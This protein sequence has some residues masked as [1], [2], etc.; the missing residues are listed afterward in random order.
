MP[1]SILRICCVR[2]FLPFFKFRRIGI[3]RN[4]SESFL[5]RY[6]TEESKVQKRVKYRRER[7]RDSRDLI[8]MKGK[9]LSKIWKLMNKV[10]PL[11]LNINDQKQHILIAIKY[12]LLVIL[13]VQILKLFVRHKIHLVYELYMYVQISLLYLTYLPAQIIISILRKVSQGIGKTILGKGEI[14]FSPVCK[15]YRMMVSL[16]A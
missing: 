14:I 16:I 13:H 10:R 12:V 8:G 11:Q 2:S 4:G 15:V 9:P 7:E 3:R 6:R 1:S 5:T